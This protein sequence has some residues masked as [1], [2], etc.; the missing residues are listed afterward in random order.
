[1]LG[2]GMVTEERLKQVVRLLT[3]L[4]QERRMMEEKELQEKSEVG[5]G[6]WKVRILE[7]EEDE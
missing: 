6:S 7:V 1:M 3:H 4:L 5:E 2:E